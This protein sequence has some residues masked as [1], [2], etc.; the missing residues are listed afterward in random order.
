MK[1]APRQCRSLRV[2]NPLT[3]WVGALTTICRLLAFAML[4]ALSIPAEAAHHAVNSEADLRN[5]I[6]NAVNGDTIGLHV[7]IT[8]TQDLPAIQRDVTILGNNKIVDGAG[9]Y[10]GFFVVKFSRDLNAPVTV[11]LQDLTIRN[12]RAGGGSGRD[13]GGGG[14]GLG[15]ALFVANLGA[16]TLSN[17]QLDTNSARGGLGGVDGLFGGGGGDGLGGIAGANAGAG[18][19][20][21]GVRATGGNGG[22][23]QDGSPGIMV[24]LPSAGSGAGSGFGLGGSD[25]GGGGGGGRANGTS[26]AGGGGGGVAG[27]SGATNG[28]GGRGGFGGGGGG[29]GDASGSG[30]IGGTG[31]GGGASGLIGVTVPG[32]SSGGFGGGGGARANGGFGAGS[33][34]TGPGF[35]GGGGG[36]ALGGALYVQE[37]GKLTLTGPLTIDGNSVSAGAGGGSGSDAGSAGSAFG[38]GIFLQGG[39][40]PLICTP[41]AGEMQTIVDDIADQAGSGGDRSRGLTKSGAGTLVLSGASNFSGATAVNAGTLIVDGTIASPVTVNSGGTLGGTGTIGNAVTVNGGGTIAPGGSPGSLS[42]A[43]VTL[44]GGSAI[45]F[46][47]GATAN[48][49]DSDLLTLSG[50]LTQGSAGTVTFHF[51][52]GVGASTPPTT[53]PLVRF[54]QESAFTESDFSYD[55]VGAN[56]TLSGTFSFGGSEDALTLLFTVTGMPVRLQS[57]DVQ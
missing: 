47:L 44:N 10:R 28:T 6:N 40:M 30:G 4:F 23:G 26:T 57:F 27:F 24:G 35:P 29:A 7:D 38:S 46:Q 45:A 41:G 8:L 54:T 20:G 37:G 13:G 32:T 21:V 16:V 33:G 56:P 52:D 53:Y 31:G 22:V 15:G 2:R 42:A 1:H 51:S 50:A 12:T 43:S 18:G 34:G 5:A 55:Y 25:G 49:G 19:G 17:I 36:A 11:T 48:P 14:A 39:G 3:P 9:V